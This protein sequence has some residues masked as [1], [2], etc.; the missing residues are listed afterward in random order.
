MYCIP[1]PV[2]Y[3]G[4]FAPATLDGYAHATNAYVYTVDGCATQP[5]VYN[6]NLKFDP[7]LAKPIGF[8]ILIDAHNGDKPSFDTPLEFQ[9]EYTNPNNVKL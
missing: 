9:Y 1:T 2:P 5:D 8:E 4:W 3:D 6:E 7:L